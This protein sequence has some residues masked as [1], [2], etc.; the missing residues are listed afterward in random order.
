MLLRVEETNL[1][2]SNA[3]LPITLYNKTCTTACCSYCE[4]VFMYMFENMFVDNILFK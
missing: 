2:K 1:S 4:S 3:K